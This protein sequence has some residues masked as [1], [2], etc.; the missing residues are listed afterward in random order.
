VCVNVCARASQIIG[1]IMFQEPITIQLATFI[2]LA[3]AGGILYTYIKEKEMQALRSH[4]S[5][6][7]VSKV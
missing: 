2:G 1:V 4:V 5:P 7:S 3:L 6:L